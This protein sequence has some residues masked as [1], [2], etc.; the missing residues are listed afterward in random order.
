MVETKNLKDKNALINKA[1]TKNTISK[2][3]GRKSA[4]KK[5][6]KKNNSSKNNRPKNPAPT[7]NFPR[8]EVEK[9]LRIPRTIL[10]Q[11]AGKDTSE[12]EVSKYIGVK[13][14]SSGPPAVEISSAIK[15]GFLERTGQKQFKL[16]D[17]S[18]RILRPQTQDDE[19]K[20]YRQAILNAPVISEVYKHYRGE[21]L[22]DRTFFENALIETFKVPQEKLTE[23]IDIFLASLTTARLVEKTGDKYR[24]LDISSE[25]DKT[26]VDTDSEIRKL[27]RN[28]SLSADDSCFVMMPFASPIGD[29]YKKIYEP[30][31]EKAGLKPIR[32]DNE[33]F[34]VGKIIDQIWEGINTAKVLIGEL[35]G[36]NANVF[37]ELG[38]AHALKK[39]VVL[40]SS[41]EGDVPFDLQHIRVIYYDV[42]DPFWGQ[43]L[44]DKV[45]ENILSA[46][47]NPEETILFK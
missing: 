20:G 28:T 39:P 27:S 8:H 23:F 32:A 40:I 18:K 12:A 19:V 47:R 21:N 11:N 15:Y 46:I 4:A 1:T 29:Y 24:L 31:I 22:P 35:T 41:N 10:E 2:K 6:V 7:S 37:Y 17:L 42:H 44:I 13:G 38:L 9:S 45:A 14:V 36:R 26:L 16:T 25:G 34:G 3:A 43:K 5:T 30:A 33:I